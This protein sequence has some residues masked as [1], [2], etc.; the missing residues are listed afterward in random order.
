MV[1]EA[2]AARQEGPRIR[3]EKETVAHMM[4]IYCQGVHL[5]AEKR[6]SVIDKGKKRMKVADKNNPA[7]RTLLCEDCYALYNYSQKRLTYCRF[8]EEKATCASCPVHCYAPQE[9]EE[10]RRV[11]RYAGARMLFRHPW[12]AFRHVLD[13]RTSRSI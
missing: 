6:H 2:K 12:L 5:E 11:M 7:K 10:I 1:Y 13:G 3:R 9:Q 4:L 8:G